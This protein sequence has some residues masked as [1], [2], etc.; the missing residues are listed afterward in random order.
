MNQENQISCGVAISQQSTL[1]TIR[2]N[3]IGPSTSKSTNSLSNVST[4]DQ[5]ADCL[6]MGLGPVSLSRLCDKMGLM[7][8]FPPSSGGALRMI[9]AIA[10]R[11][12]Q[13]LAN[14]NS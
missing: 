8:N 14:P 12:A 7:D 6:T 4:E 13:R 9:E 3:M 5:V 2:Y 1:P 11:L 10:K